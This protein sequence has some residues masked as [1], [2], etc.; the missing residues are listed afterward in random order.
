MWWWATSRVLTWWKKAS[1]LYENVIARLHGH[2]IFKM[3]TV[4][5]ITGLKKR[6]NKD[7]HDFYIL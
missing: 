3:H 2:C 6:L 4:I 7:A 5:F 1:K